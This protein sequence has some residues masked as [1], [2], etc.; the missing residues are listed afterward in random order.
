MDG[1]NCGRFSLA[2]SG[3]L[4][5]FKYTEVHF[6]SVDLDL[7]EGKTFDDFVFSTSTYFIFWKNNLF[8]SAIIRQNGILNFLKLFT[9]CYV[10]CALVMA[11]YFMV[12]VFRTYQ[13]VIFSKLHSIVLVRIIAK[14]ND[15]IIF[16][17]RVNVSFL[18]LF[19]FSM[20]FV[21]VFFTRTTE[22]IAIDTIT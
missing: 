13:K 9:F 11:L 12:Y 6:I 8:S 1:H 2:L 4:L 3:L 7:R 20:M 19:V 17:I 21:M 15:V 16:V 14:L 10:C 18:F 5:F 22:T